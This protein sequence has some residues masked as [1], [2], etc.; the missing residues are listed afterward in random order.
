VLATTGSFVAHKLGVVHAAR[1]DY[2][3]RKVMQQYY[4]KIEQGQ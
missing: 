3:G 2:S 1:F 4:S